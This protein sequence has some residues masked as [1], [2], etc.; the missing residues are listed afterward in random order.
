MH[1]GP[2]RTNTSTLTV[3]EPPAP[4]GPDDRSKKH[5]AVNI[6]PNHYAME[7]TVSGNCDE[8]IPTLLWCVLTDGVAIYM[9]AFILLH[10]DVPKTTCYINK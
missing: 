2:Q 10:L 7:Y 5:Q 3:N 4:L 1:R 6:H 9:C 8:L